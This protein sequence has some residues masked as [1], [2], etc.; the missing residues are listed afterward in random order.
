MIANYL[1]HILV[2]IERF[3]ETVEYD[4]IMIISTRQTLYSVLFPL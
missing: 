1:L 2:Q 3:I 4:I